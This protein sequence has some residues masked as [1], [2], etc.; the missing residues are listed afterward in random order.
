MLRLHNILPLQLNPLF[1]LPRLEILSF[2]HIQPCSNLRYTIKSLHNNQGER[3]SE[4]K[5][6]DVYNKNC[7]VV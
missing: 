2:E 5:G 7:I 6:Y 3:G 1:P 4:K